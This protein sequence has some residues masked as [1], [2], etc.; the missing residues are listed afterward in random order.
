MK[1][2]LILGANGQVARLAI[3]RFLRDTDAK[4]TLF[5]R[6]PRRLGRVDPAR[7][8][9]V[10]GDVLD[11]EKLKEAMYGQD[12][13]Y[14]NLAGDLERQAAGMVNLETLSLAVVLAS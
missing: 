3:D 7:A 11:A 12:V 14:A 1:N 6:N 9:V 13:V 5:L 2:V 4:L 8:S 10:E